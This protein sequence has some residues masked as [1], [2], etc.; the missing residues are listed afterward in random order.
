MFNTASVSAST[1]ATGAGGKEG[2]S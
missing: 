1:T 2:V